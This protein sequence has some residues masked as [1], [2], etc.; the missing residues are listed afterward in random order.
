MGTEKLGSILR[1]DIASS[2]GGRNGAAKRADKAHRK[3]RGRTGGEVKPQAAG[4]VRLMPARLRDT[5]G[6][7]AAPCAASSWPD[8]LAIL[9]S[10][11]KSLTAG[12]ENALHLF[13]M[14]LQ[15]LHAGTEKLNWLSERAAIALHGKGIEEAVNE[16][17]WVAGMQRDWI[18]TLSADDKNSL[19]LGKAEKI[20]EMTGA[21]LESLRQ[22]QKM[23]AAAAKDFCIKSVS[24][25]R[26]MCEVLDSLRFY[27]LTRCLLEQVVRD[28][29]S[30]AAGLD[31]ACECAARTGRTRRMGTEADLR[32]VCSGQ[33]EVLLKIKE[34]FD[35]AMKTV[36]TSLCLTVRNLSVMPDD[37][38]LADKNEKGKSYLSGMG[39]RLSAL[40]DS[41]SGFSEEA[42]R[43]SAAAGRPDPAGSGHGGRPDMLPHFIDVL[44][45]MVKSLHTTNGNILDNLSL[46]DEAGRSLSE[47]VEAVIGRLCIR[48]DMPLAAA[49]FSEG[50]TRIADEFR[51]LANPGQCRCVA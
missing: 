15:D 40:A 10:E 24:A 3:P 5:G 14:E 47:N 30:L 38:L 17:D 6:I 32:G 13:I 44:N 9:S 36:I 22:R 31:R 21:C 51:S 49:E 4:H 45:C 7:P 37:V 12:W 8:R 20:M 28:T 18:E 33:A 2:T 42:V 48:E 27:D 16:L 50:I 35:S 19:R 46:I 34:Q 43:T 23:S 1:R 25:S 41:L 39:S 11:L 29:E 26:G